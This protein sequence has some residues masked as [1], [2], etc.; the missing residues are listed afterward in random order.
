MKMMQPAFAFVAGLAFCVGATV[1][2]RSMKRMRRA[3]GFGAG[4]A[5]CFVGL[6]R[7]TAA[8]LTLRV[9]PLPAG[10]PQ[11]ATVFVAGDF[12]GWK[13]GDAM[14]ALTP[15]ADG[16]LAI[17][18]PVSIRGNIAFKFT[19]GAWTTVET[20][21]AG[22]D[23]PNR[24]FT[25]P[26]TGAV[27]ITA[28]I[29]AWKFSTGPVAAKV[30]TARPSVRIISD[31]FAI[32]SLGRTRRVWVYLPPGN[33]VG[34]QR[35]PVVYLQDG[36]N[37][38]D[39]ATSSAGEWGVDETI[40]SLASRGVAGAIVVAVDNGGSHRMDEYNP[41]KNGATRLGG[42]EGEA[43]VNFLARELKPYIDAHYRTRTDARS[44][45]IAGSSMGGLIA[46]YAS[47]TRPGVFGNAGVFSCACWIARE[48]IMALVKRTKPGKQPAHFYFVV[49][50]LEGK[51]GEPAKDQTAVVRAMNTVGFRANS[52]VVA[53]VVP[54]GKHEEWFW[55]REFPKAYLWLTGD[56]V[57][58]KP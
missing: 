12:N 39:A 16:A 8:Q 43:Y 27:T 56:Q 22:T 3:F 4:I 58:V 5:F 57:R 19:L 7:V 9:T 48:E 13:P 42:G 35:Y 37:V 52:E 53:R 11:G 21:P 34:T 50:E 14:W 15:A 47:L 17:T 18:L 24:T 36:Q 40:D 33:G 29:G 30:S 1:R 38:F 2:V 28:A 45:T 23:I 46:L 41:W 31:S 55:R 20:T 32:P 26:P 6:A 51:N 49:G 54:D 10:T 25:I 44:T